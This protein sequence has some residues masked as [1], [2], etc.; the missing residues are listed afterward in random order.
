M[1]DRLRMRVCSLLYLA[2]K[3]LARDGMQCY[4][5]V[6]LKNIGC[7]KISLA[8]NLITKNLR[9]DLWLHLSSTQTVIEIAFANKGQHKSRNSMFAYKWHNFCLKTYILGSEFI[10]LSS[11]WQPCCSYSGIRVKQKIMFCN[12]GNFCRCSTVFVCGRF[13]P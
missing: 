2:E 1:Y 7:N 9:F 11:R 3:G 10:P 6:R 12:L 8:K 4:G 5:W 13:Q